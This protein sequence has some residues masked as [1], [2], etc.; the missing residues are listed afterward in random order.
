MTQT[1]YSVEISNSYLGKHRRLTGL[2]RREVELKA[3]EQL[4]RW[5]EQEQRAKARAAVQ[6]QKYQAAEATEAAQQL[7]HQYHTILDAT[8]R[9]DD[10]VNWSGMKNSRP[11][12]KP[13]PDL[14]TIK[15]QQQVPAERPI[16]EG[17]RLR[18]KAKRLAAEERAAG[19]HRQMVDQWQQERTRFEDDRKRHNDEVDRFRADYEQGEPSAVERYASLV[20]AS[21]TFPDGFERDC[22]VAYSAPD[23][24]L[25]VECSL[26]S[27]DDIP[28]TVEYRYVASRNQTDA[29]TLKQKEAAALYEDVIIQTMLRTVH[30]VFEGDYA[31]HCQ[32][33]VVNANAHGVDKATGHDFTACIA[34]VQAERAAFVEIDLARVDPRACFRGLKG[35][36]G[37]S[38][39][40]MQPVRPIRTFDKEDSRFIE[41][42]A[43][44]DGLDADQNL[45]TMAWQDFEVLVRDIFNEVFSPKGGDVRVTRTSR[46]QGVDAVIFDPDPITGGKTVVQAKRY[47]NTVPVAAVRE[48]YGTMVNE[49]AGKGILVTTSHFGTSASEFAKDKEITLLDGPR[50]LHLMN[51]HGHRIRIDLTEAPPEEEH[52]LEHG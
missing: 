27:V 9:V 18:S 41:A 22:E 38:L 28:T 43:I 21:S 23:K 20:L 46:D 32:L 1:R 37:A 15:V 14:E 4:Q 13:E 8:L 51:N 29:K 50:L 40:Q 42:N 16:L 25:L 33:V 3:A 11:F 17:L 7:L 24:T 12:D 49:Q 47:R 36:S 39:A 6:D 45:M 30:E 52:L 31:G 5:S 2:S 10:R 26:P 48:L 34:S 44:L 19:T 35:L